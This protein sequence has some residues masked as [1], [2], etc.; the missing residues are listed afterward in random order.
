MDDL[1]TCQKALAI[2]AARPDA[3]EMPMCIQIKRGGF[4]A[5]E[6]SD[7][8]RVFLVHPCDR[9][10]YINVTLGWETLAE[11]DQRPYGFDA[12]A[13]A[14]AVIKAID[15]L[16]AARGAQ[17]PAPAYREEPTAAG[18][19]LCIPGTERRPVENGKPA[20]LSLWG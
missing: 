14:A 8:T 2:I 17:L 16:A 1:N 15:L 7:G 9:C 4:P 3:T 13:M 19:Q 11:F 18:I 10:R 6:L 5:G 20:Q 12:E